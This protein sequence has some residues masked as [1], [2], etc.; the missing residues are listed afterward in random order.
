MRNIFSGPNTFES[1]GWASSSAVP[2]MGQQVPLPV[3]QP[4]EPRELQ[5][6]DPRER[7]TPEPPGKTRLTFDEAQELLKVLDVVLQPLTAEESATEAAKTECL[8]ELS[9][10]PFPIL[11]R[12][13]DRLLEFIAV[14]DLAA[15]FSISKGELNVMEKAVTCADGIGRKA[16]IRTV[17]TVGGVGAVAALLFLL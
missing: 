17:A 7:K 9:S 4:L 5:V 8:R 1:G 2:R 13:R 16:T 15:S 11:V 6:Q 10:G 12:L 14:G 3:P